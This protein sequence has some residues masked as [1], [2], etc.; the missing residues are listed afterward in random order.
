MFPWKD[1]GR[2][3]TVGLELIISLALGY[4]GGSWLDG[5]FNGHGWLTVVGVIFG[6]VAGV[7][8][9][10]LV[11]QQLNKAAAAAE[12]HDKKHGIVLPTFPK[13]DDDRKD[14]WQISDSDS[15][16]GRNG[17]NDGSTS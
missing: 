11:T 10:V 1:Y 5:R 12:A 2:Y 6:V 14:D 15:A 9:L 16:D 17:P 7:R 8:Q 13:K 4:Y 3:G